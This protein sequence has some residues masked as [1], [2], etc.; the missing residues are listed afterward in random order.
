MNQK[1]PQNRIESV[2]HLLDLEE[3]VEKKV[4][5]E[6]HAYRC[7]LSVLVV[8]VAALGTFFGLKSL[9]DLEASLTTKIS[10]SVDDKIRTKID[11]NVAK[12]TDAYAD[13]IND[14]LSGAIQ[15]SLTTI[16]Q[17]DDLLKKA[18]TID[19][20]LGKVEEM[21]VSME[22]A[23]QQMTEM[24]AQLGVKHTELEQSLSLV[25]AS[26]ASLTASKRDFDKQLEN[27]KLEFDI[28]MGL[29][30][31]TVDGF[32]QDAKLAYTQLTEKTN[33]FE[34]GH[35]ELIQYTDELSS[36]L[37]DEKFDL[38]LQRFELDYFRVQS[39]ETRII[40][41]VNRDEAGFLVNTNIASTLSRLQVNIDSFDESGGQ[42]THLEFEPSE[43]TS[44]GFEGEGYEGTKFASS[45]SL[46]QPFIDGVLGENLEVLD[47][48][49]HVTVFSVLF[50]DSQLS[51]MVDYPSDYIESSD[52]QNSLSKDFRSLMQ[53]FY[54]AS[55]SLTIQIYLNGLPII[56][57]E[58]SNPS[59]ILEAVDDR[60]E[61]SRFIFYP[62]EGLCDPLNTREVF[63]NTLRKDTRS[64][65]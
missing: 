12:T 2:Q 21:V 54:D 1:A 50:P 52:G 18:G 4:K 7:W 13:I 34:I 11:E 32:E 8:A 44:I 61:H 14:T 30:S 42:Q 25:Q 60:E 47:G 55:L 41:T 15:Q 58:Y 3:I 48:L 36:K 31:E 5:A 9:P 46:W 53:E 56:E 51:E 62:D 38:M 45:L 10:D 24:E 33:E 57:K 65:I 17:A 6:W 40:L 49:S 26:I 43:P 22:D 39:L 29:L 19:H 28:A 35:Q 27:S 37:H 63:E 64:D 16:E 20:T 59:F 23:R